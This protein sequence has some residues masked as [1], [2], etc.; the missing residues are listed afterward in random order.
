M[1]IIEYIS[2]VFTALVPVPLPP[3][4]TVP[5]LEGRTVAR[6]YTEDRFPP[7]RDGA[8]DVQ[9]E[10]LE[11][12]YFLMLSL[13]NA[14]Q[15]VETPTRSYDAERCLMAMT[16]LLVF[17]AI[18]RQTEGSVKACM[19]AMLLGSD[20]GYYP[21]TTLGRGNLDFAT[22]AATLE[23]TNPSQLLIRS[24]VLRYIAYQKQAYRHELF[25]M[26]MPDKLEVRKT[27]STMTFLRLVLDNAGYALDAS[28]GLVAGSSE[29]DK[30]A[31]W[32]CSAR[33]P[34]AREHPEYTMLRDMVLL[35]KFLGTMEMRDAQLLRRR[36]EAD[37][38]ASWTLSFDEDTPGRQMSAG[39]RTRP[40]GPRWECGMVRGRDMDIADILVKGFGDREVLYGEGLV[41]HSPIA[42]DKLIEV[43]RPTED[44]VLHAASLPKFGGALNAEEAEVLLSCLT[45]PYIR[46][47]LLLEF[48]ASQ[49]RHTYLFEPQVQ[50]VLRAL[51]F[52]PATY[53]GAERQAAAAEVQ[54]TPVRLNRQQR[55][56]VERAHLRGDF[57]QRN[58]EDCLGTTY[59][60]LLNEMAH[61]PAGVL[62]PLERLLRSVTE[63][64]PS[65][66][67]S[68]N[69]SFV[70]FMVHL[71]R[72]VLTFCRFVL[73]RGMGHHGAVVRAYSRTFLGLLQETIVP[74]LQGWLQESEAN[75]DTPT[76]C[77]VY[78]YK[79]MVDRTLW[80]GLRLLD[81][82][83]DAACASL[84]QFLQSSTFVRAR[85][86][87]G[88][89]MQRTQLAAREGDDLLTPE[90]KVM[91]F[92][93]AQGLDTSRVTTEML[94]EGKRLMMSGGRRR[95]VFV[96][97]RSRQHSDTVRMPNLFHSD[98]KSTTESRQ[99]KLP[100]AD[101]MEHVLF[102]DLLEDHLQIIHYLDGLRDARRDD[103]FTAVVRCVL[104]DHEDEKRAPAAQGGQG[105]GLGSLVASTTN[106]EDLGGGG[107]GWRTTS[108]GTYKGPAGTGLRFHA[109]TCEL[110]WRNDELKPV[111][112]SMSHFT[113]FETVLGKE[114]LQCGLVN[115]H[116]HRHWV[117]IVGTVYDVVEWTAPPS[118][119]D[120]GAHSPLLIA[121]N[122]PKEPVESAVFNG[123]TYDRAVA[124]EEDLPWP[125]REERWAVD[126]LRQALQG[127][128]TEI[129]FAPLAAQRKEPAAAEQPSPVPEMHFLMNDAPQYEG[130][131]DR[132]TWKEAVAYDAPQPYLEV[133][134][135]VPH[136]RKMYRSLVFTTNQRYCLHSVALSSKT[137]AR[138]SL[139]LTAFQG[140]DL[141]RRIQRESSLEI[142]RYNDAIRGREM[143]LPS[144]LLQGLVP[145][146]LL[147]AFMLWQ[148][149]DGVLRGYAI[150][151]DTS[152]ARDVHVGPTPGAGAGSDPW[153]NY[154]I[155]VHFG[156]RRQ[157]Q[158][159]Y[160]HMV[161]V[162]R[163]PHKPYTP[164][165]AATGAPPKEKDGTQEAAAD[166]AVT[167]SAVDEEAEVHLVADAALLHANFLQYPEPLCRHLLAAYSRRTQQ[168]ATTTT[169]PSSGAVRVSDISEVIAWVSSPANARTVQPLVEAFYTAAAA[170]THPTAAPATGSA[171]PPLQLESDDLVLLNLRRCAALRPLLQLFTCVEDCSHILVVGPPD[172]LRRTAWL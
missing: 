79:S 40:V 58:D 66:V 162:R 55:E 128:F 2:W 64:G 169:D 96:H 102:H 48:F 147:E 126:L 154:L 74:L 117:H 86:G 109:Q 148:G 32:L 124:V 144:R 137:R 36:K 89:G 151:E 99:L 93:Q 118:L 78:S 37:P 119:A 30:L 140:G 1:H 3:D 163:D 81:G 16:M 142:H 60:L 85:H 6:F 90:E 111:P 135:L 19:V 62:R 72:D 26:R 97:I 122:F 52:E 158:P 7:A 73:E 129:R 44:D 83:S 33:S 9:V 25:D 27:D 146:V 35:A 131:E 145:S 31:D 71:V 8:A 28:G 77:V 160:S 46:I 20:G 172:R 47:P 101:V 42:V 21:S 159:D 94:E 105:R 139:H 69:A 133:H 155:E 161:V 125:V 141:A 165:S 24:A 56:A 115:R 170:A 88:M 54:S 82:D 10:L 104:L 59:G 61:A 68:A 114:M 92:L 11:C 132:A 138:E 53:V 45:T 50:A 116:E 167:M 67:Y 130:E 13:A 143:Y 113:D 17:D 39:W 98:P 65:S 156:A 166:V 123:V 149:E 112:D 87:F 95:A 5:P 153:F 134:N 107:G 18:L 12:I 51:L 70:L 103:V 127:A 110:F 164:I 38:L 76:Q 171:R 29:M 120:Q 41:L 80:Q 100:P 150:T 168:E 91:R 75:A 106:L 84:E 57:S 63:L 152:G 157:A 4:A 14:W 22:V 23:L 49:D 15:A 121:G 43:E 34:L 136:A 108:P